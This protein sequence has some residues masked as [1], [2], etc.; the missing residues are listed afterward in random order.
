MEKFLKTAV[1]AAASGGAT[2]A[3][4]A[5]PAASGKPRKAEAIQPPAAT[6]LRKATAQAD[7]QK[8]S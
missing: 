4:R 2:I 7:F 5:T 3:P 1:A 8:M 6:R